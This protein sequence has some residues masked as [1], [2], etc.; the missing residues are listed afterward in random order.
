MAL[1]ETSVT[2]GELI[3][4]QLV[5]LCIRIK[6]RLSIRRDI[7]CMSVKTLNVRLT[8]DTGADDTRADDTGAVNTGARSL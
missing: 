4:G 3:C 5:E 7:R 2:R 6:V 8:V 1:V